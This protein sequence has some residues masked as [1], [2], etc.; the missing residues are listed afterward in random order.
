[1]NSFKKLVGETAIYGVSSIV[2]RFLNWWLVPY[3]SHIFM[4][5]EYGIVTNLYSYMA[6]LL[7]LLTYGMETGYFRFASAHE[8]K[9]LVYS[10]SMIS[11]F[12]TSAS[13]LLVVYSFSDVIAGWLDYAKHPEYVTWIA[14]IMAFDAFTSIPFA[15]LRIEG[16]AIKFAVIKIVNIFSNIF[17]N[18]FFLTICPALLKNNPTSLV[19]LIYSDK[20]SV[21][22]VFISNLIASGITFILLLPELKVKL[23]FSGKLLKEMV[24][25]SFPILIVGIAGM[26][27]QNIDKILIPELI[28]ALQHPMEQL[29]I[30]GANYKLAV[31]MNMFIQAF[32]Y[33]FEPFFFSQA[34]SENNKNGYALVLKYFVI[35]GLLI[36]LGISLF[37]DLF[38]TFNII[39][40]EYFS[41][42]KVVPYILMANLFL[43]IYYTLS[44]WYKLTD[45]TRYG[46]YFALI[47]AAI[48]LIINILFIPVYG[49]MASAVAV[50]IS[51]IV[52]SV[53]SY[54]IGQR[55]Y[56]VNY[57]MK[58]IFFYFLVA[59][60]I[61]SFSLIIS[62]EGILLQ[63]IFHLLLLIIFVT[64]VYI[65]ENKEFQKFL[66]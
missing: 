40:K 39:D 35:L 46:A 14:F 44:L 23:K 42:L 10:S 4:T 25:Y 37:L 18:I 24:L 64:T 20:I 65:L 57:P 54:V 5:A 43:G 21:G 9:G 26:V 30:Y 56:P 33:A 62:P 51:F 8:D 19:N 31:L 66:R 16:K 38:K 41:G 50:L 32:R 61:Y 15:K 45:K 52:M 36:F 1:M 49:Y 11:L 2:G 47:G 53:L 3:Y 13:F 48:N 34:K 63:N 22:Y 55:H 12:F 17:F 7:V 59:F 6:F 58:R 27:N 60:L 29:G 28:P